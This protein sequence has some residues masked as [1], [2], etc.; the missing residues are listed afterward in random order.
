MNVLVAQSSQTLGEHRDCSLPGSSV[1]GIFQTRILEWVPF[2]SPW[3][4]PDP[5]IE[6]ASL[7]SP[8]LAAGF[9]TTVPLGSPLLTSAVQRDDT[10]TLSC[11]P[12]YCGL[13]QGLEYSSLY[14]T[15]GP[16]PS[17]LS[18]HVMLIVCLR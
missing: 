16:G 12:F 7:G 4:L 9:S 10:S 6:P 8:A 3:D 18:I 5:R 11:I 15:G 2:P 1:H 17:V 14:H 13:L